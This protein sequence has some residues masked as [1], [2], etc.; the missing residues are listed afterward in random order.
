MAVCRDCGEEAGRVNSP[1]L[2]TG[3]T[4]SSWGMFAFLFFWGGMGLRTL[5]LLEVRGWL[6]LPRNTDNCSILIDALPMAE[7]QESRLFFDLEA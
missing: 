7:F 2:V 1:F 4:L 6:P 3:F 5:L